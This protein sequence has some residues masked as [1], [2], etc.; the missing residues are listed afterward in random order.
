[1]AN[2]I[3]LARQARYAAA[4]ADEGRVAD[5]QRVAD[6]AAA[7]ARLLLAA[8]EIQLASGALTVMLRAMLL[9]AATPA[10][11]EGSS[12]EVDIGIKR[13]SAEALERVGVPLAAAM[14]RS[15]AAGDAAVMASRAGRSPRE[16]AA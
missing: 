4:A 1:M 6:D 12:A 3:P 13:R 8:G 10:G 14:V 16:G 15:A 9:R 11:S 5:L 2:D 7:D